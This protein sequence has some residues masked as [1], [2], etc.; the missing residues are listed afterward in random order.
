MGKKYII[1]ARIC[2]NIASEPLEKERAHKTA[3]DFKKKIPDAK[4]KVTKA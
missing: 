4:V 2:R 1:K 3:K